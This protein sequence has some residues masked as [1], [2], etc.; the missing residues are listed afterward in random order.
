[1][2]GQHD[3]AAFS[4]ALENI[5]WVGLTFGGQYFWGHGVALDNGSAKFI[6]ID[7]RIE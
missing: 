5:G 1:M 6:L 2:I 7:F 4:S 3:A